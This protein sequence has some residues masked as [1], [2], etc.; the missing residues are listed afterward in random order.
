MVRAGVIFVVVAFLVA[1]TVMLSRAR[2]ADAAALRRLSRTWSWA[3][4]VRA[5]APS[6]VRLVLW[7]SAGAPK[8]LIGL[9][10]LLLSAAPVVAGYRW[11]RLVGV[12]LLLCLLASIGMAVG[13]QHLFAL[14]PLSLALT[15]I[16]LLALALHLQAGRTGLHA[17][18]NSAPSSRAPRKTPVERRDKTRP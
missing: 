12:S 9:G 18:T 11:P 14:L 5:A 7:L 17:H 6:T 8:A 4:F 16:W 1:A 2:R 15:G 10:G 3:G 13:W